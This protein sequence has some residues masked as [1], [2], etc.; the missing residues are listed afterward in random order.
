M[1]RRKSKFAGFTLIELL[2]VIAIIAILVALLLPAVQQARE[3][4]R[5]S[6]CKNNL[7]QIGLALHNYHDV[8]STLPIGSRSGP[9]ASN[10]W[11]TWGQSWWVAVLPYIDQAPLYNNWNH[12]PANSGYNQNLPVIDGVKISVA[13]CPSSPLPDFS[14]ENG[15]NPSTGNPARIS[16]S[17]YAGISGAYVDATNRDPAGRNAIELELSTGPA[18]EGGVMF[19]DSKIGFR[20]ISDG[21]S[22]TIVVGEQSD[23][24]VGATG[25]QLIHLSSYP[26][27]MFMGGHDVTGR[28]F[29]VTTV[30]YTPGYRTSEAVSEAQPNCPL[31]GVCGNVGANNP[32]Q[33]IHTGGAHVLLGDGSVRFAS[34]NVNL[35]T[36]LHLATR[37]DGNVLGTW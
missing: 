30:R 2:V 35:T 4:A 16:L 36:F 8:H 17:N 13:K 32:I 10:G 21:L 5:R 18:T 31:T 7:K 22:N 11:S 25:S 28:R 20:D 34:N 23:Y 1:C 9:R 26:A 15:N 27:G 6:Q 14:S 19:F 33:S 12:N 24:L 29:N 3:A 37:D